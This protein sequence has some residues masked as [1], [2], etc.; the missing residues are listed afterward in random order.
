LCL[1]AHLTGAEPEIALGAIGNRRDLAAAAHATA[2]FAKE[3]PDK[4]KGHGGTKAA[5]PDSL[6]PALEEHSE[7]EKA[8]GRQGG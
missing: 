4:L 3:L 8:G 1:E 6:Y 7:K 5:P 2:P